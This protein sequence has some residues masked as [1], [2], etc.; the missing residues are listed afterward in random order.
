MTCENQEKGSPRA[1]NASPLT[2]DRLRPLFRGSTSGSC[3][4]IDH[5]RG[6][7]RGRK[8]VI[9]ISLD[10]YLPAPDYGPRGPL[11]LNRGRDLSVTR[12][13]EFSVFGSCV[14][15]SRAGPVFS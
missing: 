5:I 6:R 1:L 3:T 10:S 13:V 8:L 4:S 15:F 9:R 12:G 2:G 7:G 14:A 11:I